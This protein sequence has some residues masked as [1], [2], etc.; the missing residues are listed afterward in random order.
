MYV[1]GSDRVKFGENFFVAKPLQ[2]LERKII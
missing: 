2:L 1:Q